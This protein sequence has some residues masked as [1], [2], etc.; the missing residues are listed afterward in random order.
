MFFSAGA[1][2]YL[3]EELNTLNIVGSLIVIASVGFYLFMQYRDAKQ[4]NLTKDVELE[5]VPSST[6]TPT[7][8]VHKDGK[9]L[10][11]YPERS[12]SISIDLSTT[13]SAV[14]DLST[15]SVGSEHAYSKQDTTS[16]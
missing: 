13:S 3:N 10:T 7:E 15:S 14:S 16:I 4:A 6:L 2:P 8:T 12:L 5:H 9:V 11:E 1:S